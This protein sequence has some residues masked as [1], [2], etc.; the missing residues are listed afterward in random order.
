MD[1]PK[2]AAT[3]CLLADLPVQVTGRDRAAFF[4]RPL[5]TADRTVPYIRIANVDLKRA[6]SAK[7]A[8]KK[9]AKQ[10][11]SRKTETT[12]PDTTAAFTQTVYR[13]SGTLDHIMQL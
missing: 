2:P 9:T 5:A 12:V 8:K 7:G 11:E 10:T 1:V 3:R 13:E 4:A 6:E